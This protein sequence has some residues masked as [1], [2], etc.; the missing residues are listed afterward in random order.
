MNTNDN[1]TKVIVWFSCFYCNSKDPETYKRRDPVDS[2]LSLHV[3]GALACDHIDADGAC[4]EDG[5]AD[6]K[7][8]TAVEGHV[9]P[10]VGVDALLGAAQADQGHQHNHNHWHEGVHDD[11]DEDVCFDLELK[12]EGTVVNDY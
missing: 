9:D 3:S 8:Q 6:G 2:N 7:S 11:F 12:H 5:E 1:G 4:A 10:L